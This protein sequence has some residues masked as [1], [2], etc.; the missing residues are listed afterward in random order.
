MYLKSLIFFVF[1]LNFISFP[2][3]AKPEEYYE[4]SEIRQRMEKREIISVVKIVDPQRENLRVLDM[5]AAGVIEG[6]PLDRAIELMSD[7]ENLQKIAPEYIKLS[8]LIVKRHKEKGKKKKQYLKYVHMKTEV[9]TLLG[10]YKVEVYSK[11]QEEKFPEKGIVYWE[12]VPGSEVGRSDAPGD[13]VGLK[14]FVTVEKYQRFSSASV[15]SDLPAGRGVYRGRHQ[16]DQAFMLFKGKMEKDQKGISKV[17]PNFILQ[18]AM[19]V[20]L[21]RVGILLRNYLETM[22]DVPHSPK[23]LEE[24]AKEEDVRMK[25]LA[26]P[27]S[28]GDA[29]TPASQ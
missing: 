4:K 18:F 28:S 29:P 21:Q 3:F 22:K 24:L 20:A 6:V 8:E 26:K 1:I 13:F 7:Y 27:K 14:G 2:L 16:K 23:S 9:S 15:T 17:V 25:L 5:A 12:I 11:V 10:T 19:E